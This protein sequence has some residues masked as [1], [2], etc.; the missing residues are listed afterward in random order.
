MQV[1]ERPPRPSNAIVSNATPNSVVQCAV[2]TFP[3]AIRCNV[4]PA[5]KLAMGSS[6]ATVQRAVDNFPTATSC[7]VSPAPSVVVD[8]LTASRQCAVDTFPTAASCIV[9]PAS[10][11][12]V[13]SLTASRQRADNFPTAASGIAPP[14]P[15]GGDLHSR[16]TPC[17]P[18]R[19][20]TGRLSLTADEERRVA[21]TNEAMNANSLFESVLGLDQDLF[22]AM[23]WVGAR[24]DPQ[25]KSE[26][27]EIMSKLEQAAVFCRSTGK[28]EH[29]LEGCC[30]IIRE[31][32]TDVCGPL[33]QDLC[34][35]AEHIDRDAPD[36]L[37][38][39]GPLLGQLPA[40]GNGSKYAYPAPESVDEVWQTCAKANAELLQGLREDKHSAYLL[41]QC[42]NDVAVHRMSAPCE[43]SQAD[44]SASRLSP[45]FCVEQGYNYD[46]INLKLRAIDD[47]SRS[48][49]NAITQASE[50]L[51]H[52]SID[53]LFKSVR[54]LVR[55]GRKVQLWK[56]DIDAAYR[57][58]PIC[59]E[60]RWAA[61][62]TFAHE[63]MK[64]IS[65]HFTFPFGAR[66]AV[67]AWDRVG[68]LLTS[69]ARRILHLPILRYVDDFYAVAPHGLAEH[70]MN[71]FARLVRCLLGPSAISESKLQYGMPLP[72]LGLSVEAVA[73][74]MT[75]TPLPNKISKWL[76]VIDEALCT[77]HF[78]PA[79]SG[80]LA[81]ALS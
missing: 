34:D 55:T 12:A 23:S 56:A 59:P 4:S 28:C 37:R 33:L 14:A 6:I 47:L 5:A 70:S 66:A 53:A 62:V 44:L 79:Q 31:L 42:L 25:I 81:G 68:S 46:G 63:G 77:G 32:A 54:W 50:K 43:A 65:Q 41:E 1:T 10:S 24:N 15:I 13:D 51:H 9:S 18:R 80:K 78:T 38:Y 73:E 71:I 69:I 72:I 29:W 57:R 11:L 67:H 76:A 7:I 8:S 40:T 19:L 75:C 48:L 39:G 58:V 2:D 52:D 35:L 27:E 45:R 74:G 3:T 60:H 26:Q 61:G 21:F 17:A 30:E 49:V 22:E 64:Y 20:E 16:A 36:T